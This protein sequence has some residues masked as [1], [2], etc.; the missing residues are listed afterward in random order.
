MAKMSRKNISQS[1][2]IVNADDIKSCLNTMNDKINELFTFK[3][4]ITEILCL[5]TKLKKIIHEKENEVKDLKN[6]VED[7]EQHTL[8]DNLIIEGYKTNHVL[9]AHVA[10]NNNA[11]TTCE[12][13][14]QDEMDSHE[15]Q[16]VSYFNN[17]MLANIRPED[18]SVCHSVRTKPP[19]Q[20]I[21][22]V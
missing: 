20:K 22:I 14:S 11:A 12:N 1:T 8:R 13:A 21:I 4:E 15:C 2:N 10:S 5:A 17:K 16:V 6:R 7:L 3:I 18:I 9:Y 19:Q